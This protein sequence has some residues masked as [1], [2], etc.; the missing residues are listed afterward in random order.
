MQHLFQKLIE[1]GQNLL[2]VILIVLLY[3]IEQIFNRPFELKNR[4]IHFLHGLPLQLGYM[5]VNYGLAF[6]LVAWVQWIKTHHFG[7]LYQIHIA[8]PAKIILGFLAIDFTFYWAHRLYHIW[9]LPW[10]LHRVHHSDISVDS[11]TFF[12]FH[13]FDAIMD[14]TTF[15][16]ASGIFGIDF[17]TLLLFFLV[18]LVFTIAQHS[19]FVFPYWTDLILGKVFMTPNLHKVHQHQ[20]QFYTDSNFGLTFIIW[21]RIFG[22]YKYLPVQEIKYGLEEFDDNKKQTFWYLLKSPFLNIKRISPHEKDKMH[23][24]AVKRRAVNTVKHY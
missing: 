10:R 24:A 3:S 12:R 21:D 23:I 17:N 13:P 8:Y 14:N 2:M 20:N 1:V 18:N 7:I 6:V 19:K 5:A 11:S 9:S 15:M 4:S 16:I 22:T